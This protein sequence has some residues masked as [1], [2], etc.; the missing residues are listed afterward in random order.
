MEKRRE[1]RQ[2]DEGDVVELSLQVKAEIT[3]K[4][5]PSADGQSASLQIKPI[6]C[7]SNCG[8]CCGCHYSAFKSL[9]EPTQ[10]WLKSNQRVSF[11]GNLAELLRERDEMQSRISQLEASYKVEETEVKSVT[12]IESEL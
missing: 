12:R 2:L 3:A 4:A 9:L 5:E 10:V 6:P 11:V 1:S 7:G 8:E